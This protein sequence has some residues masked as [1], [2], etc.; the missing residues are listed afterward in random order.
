MR[1][2]L[3]TTALLTTLAMS[4][5]AAAE[6]ND[7]QVPATVLLITSDELADAWSGYRDWKTRLGKATKV[8]TVSAISERY[9]GKDVQAKIRACVRA[10]VDGQGTRWVVLGGDSLPGGQGIVPDRDTRHSIHGGRI[11]YA[12]IPT[13]LYYVTK[14][15]WDVNKDGVYGDWTHDVKGI[16]YA[17]IAAIGRI[18]VR[19]AADVAAFTAKVIAYETRYPKTD[20]AK[21]MLYTNAVPMANYKADMLWDRY[22]APAWD[23]GSCQKFFANA[24]PW[25]AQRPGDYD[26]S[27]KNWAARINMQTAGKMHMHGHGF[28]PGWVLERH[29]SANAGT[30]AQLKNEDAYLIMTTVSCFTGQFDAVKD[31]SIT[32]SMLRQPKGGA[33]AIVTC[34]REGVPVF[35]GRPSDPRDGKTQD[36]TTR[37]LTRFW[38]H[39]LGEG[40]TTGEALAKA[41]ADLAKDAKTTAGFHWVL[42][43]INLLGDPTLDMRA[44]DPI[45]PSVKAP[46]AL[47]LGSK[48]VKVKTDAPGLTVCL[49]KAGDVFAVQTTDSNGHATFE[50][51]TRT[52]GDL[53]LTVSGPSVNA[54]TRTIAI[55][56]KGAKSKRPKKFFK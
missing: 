24:S 38:M 4:G 13:D 54:V 33:V 40:L 49:Y 43:E 10:H 1:T 12:D 28:L 42:S 8:V 7:V 30:V 45:S 20:F 2:L 29:Q 6:D 32:E 44:Q 56:A 36:G 34:A 27:P 55:R 50:I 48:T 16:D 39:G 41:K 3:A 23:G 53:L 5:V 35:Q 9:E 17:P 14:G 22:L 11:R 47:A 21:R 31:P 52:A 37:L 18:P 19:T 15:D 25:D 46:K 26:L 51:E